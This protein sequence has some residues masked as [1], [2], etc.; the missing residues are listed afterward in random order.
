MKIICDDKIPF[1]RGALDQIAHVEY[2]PGKKIGPADVKDADALI[3][4]TRTQCDAMLL[5]G[6]SVQFIAT[7]TIGYD[8]IDTAYCRRA[9]IVWTNAPGCNSSSVQQYIAAALFLLSKKHRITLTDRTLGIVG[10]GHVGSKVARLAKTIGMRTLLNDPPRQ[11]E[12]GGTEFASLEQVLAESDIITF[13]TPLNKSG[14]YKTLHL[15]DEQFFEKLGKKALIINSARGQ[16]V[17]GKALK[18]SIQN[19]M[20]RAAILD[21]W[22]EE[23][24]LDRELMDTVDIATPHIA[25]YSVDGK[26]NGTM[27]SVRALSKHFRLGMDEWKPKAIPAPE[28]PHFEIDCKLLCKEEILQKA[29]S[30]TYDIQ[31]DDARLRET[32]EN[33]EMHRGNYPDRREF[34]SYTIHLTNDFHNFA[35]LLKKLGFNVK[36]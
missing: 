28:K 18:H 21:V 33:F 29:I 10:V 15:A 4:R 8:H 16:V 17:K 1:L 13:H 2:L 7:A 12:E 14:A 6:S 36:T 9:G 19:G 3:V 31:Q 35:G 23:P 32:P 22:E 24:R 34:D 5:E 11:W 26:A 30:H 27:M 20:V 25:G